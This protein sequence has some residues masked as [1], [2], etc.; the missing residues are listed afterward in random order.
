[1]KVVVVGA[2]ILGASIASALH[3]N[4]ADVQVVEANHIPASGATGGSWAWINSNQKS[5]DAYKQLNYE[6]M[7]EWGKGAYAQQWI[8]S[9]AIVFSREAAASAQGLSASDVTP[10]YPAEPLTHSQVMAL[11]PQLCLDSEP[12]S[13]HVRHDEGWADPAL[14]TAMLLAP[15]HTAGR[16]QYGAPVCRL[17]QSPSGPW[18]V[19]REG[20]DTLPA[21]TVIVA[22][23]IGSP[24]LLASIPFQLPLQFCPGLLAHTSPLPVGSIRRP[25]VSSTVHLLQR[26]DGRV[27]I[28]GDLSHGGGGA[29]PQCEPEG[30]ASTQPPLRTV[31]SK[32]GTPEEGEMWE[33]GERLLKHASKLLPALRGA[34]LEKVT[35]APRP[36]PEDGYPALGFVCPGV[37]LAITHSAVTLAPLL[38]RLVQEEVMHGSRAGQLE[39]FRPQRFPQSCPSVS[40]L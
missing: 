12:G 31:R 7:L 4:G 15:L 39:P 2:G 8:K 23:G 24:G 13:A 32:G 34:R 38:G 17:A 21:D 35:Q 22:A 27:V 18:V 26:G 3:K 5:P 37:Y 28:G 16:V 25:V 11:E 33:E 40:K 1:M 6:S 14:S 9:G 29:G 20:G 10:P 30:W 36:M 19:H